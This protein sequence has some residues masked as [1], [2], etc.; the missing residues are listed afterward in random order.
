ML[1]EWV[2]KVYWQ[3]S[4]FFVWR[5]KNIWN[6]FGT[7]CLDVLGAYS[8]S[9]KSVELFPTQSTQKYDIRNLRLADLTFKIINFS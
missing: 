3:T 5:Q 9:N 6:K 4:Q 7:A 8:V 2:K 1:T